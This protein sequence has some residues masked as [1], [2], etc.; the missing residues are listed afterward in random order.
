MG[1]VSS[2]NYVF[3]LCDPPLPPPL[4]L[5]STPPHHCP[6]CD[7]VRAG[8]SLPQGP[9]SPPSWQ[10]ISST[11]QPARLCTAHCA[12][13][14]ALPARDRTRHNSRQHHH[15]RSLG[16]ACAPLVAT[17]LQAALREPHTRA[18]TP[19]SRLRSASHLY[20]TAPPNS[21]SARA[22]AMP[23]RLC[24]RG[25]NSS[26]LVTIQASQ[27]SVADRG[28][29]QLK[30]RASDAGE[31]RA[32]RARVR[33]RMAPGPSSRGGGVCRNASCC[34]VV[35][36]HTG[37]HL[38]LVVHHRRVHDC[39]RRQPRSRGGGVRR[40]ASCCAVAACLAGRLRHASLNVLR[41]RGR[42]REWSR[43]G[44]GGD[45]RRAGPHSLEF[46]RNFLRNFCQGVAAHR[47]IFARDGAQAIRRTAAARG[48]GS[49][50]GGPSEHT[51]T[52]ASTQ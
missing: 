40:T 2:K 25:R 6:L 43:S 18:H 17:P 39:R 33:R 21:A 22:I 38:R 10:P 13:Q 28:A 44:G 24:K 9:S 46:F 48:D 26:I 3:G 27:K 1:G 51:H 42:G 30:A 35:V 5:P 37:R 16:L 52:Q 15:G 41:V 7:P 14:L 32:R 12:C 4:Q 45:G 19:M 29:K 36:G 8:K 31:A 11:G 23:W 20:T 47:R 50:V 49:G 34:A